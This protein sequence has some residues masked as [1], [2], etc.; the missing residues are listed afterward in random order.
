[1]TKLELNGNAEG[2]LL[3]AKSLSKLSKPIAHCTKL[4]SLW[5]TGQPLRECAVLSDA[6][7]TN[8]SITEL[9]FQS[10]PL[11]GNQLA[12][13]LQ[14]H[15]M[16]ER[17]TLQSMDGASLTPVLDAFAGRWGL[18]HLDLSRSD[19]DA[20]D[21]IAPLLAR[22]VRHAMTLESLLLASCG[23]TGRALRLLLDD[24][25]RHP[26]LR[27]LDLDF[28]LQDDLDVQAVGDMLS[29]NRT[30][31]ELHFKIQR[32]HLS[33][34]NKG[35]PKLLRAFDKNTTLTKVHR[36]LED[37]MEPAAQK[38]L[39]EYLLRNARTRAQNASSTGLLGTFSV[40]AAGKVSAAG[41]T[42]RAFPAS[43]ISAAAPVEQPSWKKPVA[44]A[45][46]GQALPSEGEELQRAKDDF[47]RAVAEFDD[48]SHFLW[49]LTLTDEQLRFAEFTR[50]PQLATLDLSQNV[51]SDD[52]LL[53]LRPLH[54]LQSL[55][56]RNNQLSSLAQTGLET[57]PLLHTLDLRDNNFS[58]LDALLTELRGCNALTTLF[59]FHATVDKAVTATPSSFAVT[60]FADL[61]GLH[62]CDGV[63]NTECVRAG[64]MAVKAIDVLWKLGRV[65]PNNLKRVN[66]AHKQ[67]PLLLLHSV[68]SALIYLDVRELDARGNEWCS[69]PSYQDSVLLSLGP[70]FCWLDGEAITNARR[71]LAFQADKKDG[72]SQTWRTQCARMEQRQERS[73]RMRVHHCRF[74]FRFSVFR[75]LASSRPT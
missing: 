40:P 10:C 67:L 34:L 8:T 57:L 44:V 50:F 18:R 13:G 19:L 9:F 21:N 51:F 43:A 24:L 74:P 63:R 7:A 49:S 41:Q 62:T 12:A 35:F 59:A 17:L 66:L 3:D 70:H 58:S 30:L 32:S 72:V 52:A 16:L 22:L 56:L 68:L 26:S 53:G 33:L 64:P 14:R 23:L 5:L 65:G 46:A 29:S 38:Q 27:L 31:D 69:A 11:N 37:I 55:T 28:N 20:D 6:L 71:M 73:M 36:A 25:H 2:Q 45:S 4:T 42:L 47:A 1:L 39:Q 54:Q 75:N 60:V 48:S 61:R 15:H